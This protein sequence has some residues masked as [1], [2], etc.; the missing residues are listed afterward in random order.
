M[1]RS[2]VVLLLLGLAA[3][4]GQPPHEAWRRGAA[5]F[6][7]AYAR[8]GD[9]ACLEEPACADAIDALRSVPPGA[10]GYRDSMALLS[11]IFAAR[12]DLDVPGPRRPGAPEGASTDGESVAE[13]PEAAPEVRAS[14]S[15][16][17]AGGEAALARPARGVRRGQTPREETSGP[18][19]DGAGEL[20]ASVLPGRHRSIPGWQAGEQGYRVAVGEH[21]Q[22]GKPL[23]LYFCTRE[24]VHCDMLDQVLRDPRVREVL[25]PA[26]RVR[27]DTEG[28]PEE[29]AIARRYGITGTPTLLVL[30]GQG[31]PVRIHPFTT[32]ALGQPHIQNAEDFAQVLRRTLR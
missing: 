24:I 15:P 2:I 28:G 7:A 31:E 18:P 12:A 27:L 26:E 29:Q 16:G 8:T 22:V 3:C 4:E 9:P 10:A 19:G 32:N 6:A 17:G 30:R 5:G 1:L 20:V 23:V 21:E 11:R 25:G 13:A 14:P